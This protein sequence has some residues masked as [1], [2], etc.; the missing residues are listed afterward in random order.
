LWL[1]IPVIAPRTTFSISIYGFD[2]TTETCFRKWTKVVPTGA[3]RLT[4]EASTYPSNSILSKETAMTDR[5]KAG[6]RGP[7]RTCTE[8][9]DYPAGKFVITTEFT[10]DGKLLST[11]HLNPDGSQWVTSQFY[12]AAGRL[13]KTSTGKLGEVSE[14]TIRSYDETGRLV[15][16]TNSV[17]NGDRTEFHYDE[18]G[19][20]TSIQYFDPQTLQRFED[21]QVAVAGSFWDAATSSGIGVPMGGTISTSYNQNGLPTEAD[22]RNAAGQTVTRFV[23]TYDVDGRVLEERSVSKN[24]ARGF[25]DQLLKNIPPEAREKVAPEEIEKINR[26]LAAI[27]GDE[28]VSTMSYTYDSQGRQTT[29]RRNHL[30]FESV[31]STTYNDHGEKLEER[32]VFNP[33]T[34]FVSG[35]RAR[36][37]GAG[38]TQNSEAESPLASHQPPKIPTARFNYEYDSYG[39][40]IEQTVGNASEPDGLTTK[41]SR[42]LTYFAAGDGGQ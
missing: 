41:R 19:H 5:E 40:W 34:A 11:R 8:E 23:R 18:R 22:I 39:N 24:V 25:A 26:T 32:Q 12:D 1:D 17:R 9:M 31:A 3:S 7:V 38:L 28:Q 37:Q 42:K 21:G 33:N 27:L 16:V 2:N 20:K 6:F 14:D 15:L 10:L 13:L 36:L 29:T 35:A 4:C 30:S